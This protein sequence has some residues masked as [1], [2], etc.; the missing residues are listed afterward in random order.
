[1]NL[2]EDFR[3]QLRKQAIRAYPHRV[4]A[5]C[6]HRCIERECGVT[7]PLSSNWKVHMRWHSGEKPFQCNFCDAT[8]LH[9][10][11]RVPWRYISALTPVR[12]PSSAPHATKLSPH[13]VHSRT[14]SVATPAWRLMHA[15][16]VTRHSLDHRIWK[17]IWT[18]IC[19]NRFCYFLCAETQIKVN[20]CHEWTTSHQPYLFILYFEHEIFHRIL[21]ITS[22][23]NSLSQSTHSWG[24]CLRI[25]SYSR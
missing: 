15:S 12:S 17:Y 8:M 9:S 11:C 24:T 1:M 16:S 7:F 18:S 4:A 5:N 3:H 22:N 25:G 10:I 21:Q 19:S 23:S 20:F 6:L 2:L 13:P 14:T